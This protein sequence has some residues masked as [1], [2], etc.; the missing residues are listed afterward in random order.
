MT[1]NDR[2]RRLRVL[3]LILNLGETNGQ[4]NEHCLPM[5]GVRDLSIC[6]YFETQLTPPPE[7]TLFEGDGSLVGFFRTFRE[8]LKEKRF[9]VIHAHAPQTGA[10]V[11]LTLLVLLRF[12]SLRPSMVYTVQDSFYDYKLRNQAM[13]VIALAGF[14]RIVF[15]SRSAYESLPAIWKALVRGRWTVVQNGADFDR[16]DEALGVRPAVRDDTVFTVVSVGRLE[17]V[18]DP[19]TLLEAFSG[20]ADDSTRLVMI[21]TGALETD[22]RAHVARLDLEDRVELTG[23]IPRDDVF[24]RCASADVLVSTS[25][26]EG[27]PVAVIEAMATECPVILSDIPPHRELADGAEFI[28]LI[29]LGDADGFAREIRR[30]RAMAPDERRR[31][32][33]L[34]RDHVVARYTLPIMHAGIESVYRAL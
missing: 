9:D 29:P 12:R 27:L 5:I 31:L 30:F 19:E 26:G 13:M 22:V 32:G 23:L 28:P 11:V 33:D 21:G 15:C 20:S 7:I 24:V 17:R 25:H 4:Y 16:I 1:G 6:T 14:K 10:L 8:T 34:S 3:H 18:K 2:G